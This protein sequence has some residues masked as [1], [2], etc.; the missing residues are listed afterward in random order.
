LDGRD[1]KL[2]TASKRPVATLNI[3]L[4]ITYIGKQLTVTIFNVF[5]V[6]LQLVWVSIRNLVG[7]RTP[8]K[9]PRIPPIYEYN[10]CCAPE[11]P[12]HPDQISHPQKTGDISIATYYNC[13]SVH[14]FCR[15]E[16]A[17]V[18]IVAAAAC[19]VNF[20]ELLAA[21]IAA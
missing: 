13:H 1:N 16:A 4:T 18:A 15:V 17:A 2:K 5:V 20:V 12:A 11:D 14:I 21:L 10:R 7:G 19:S 8:R 3:S 9:T 6:V